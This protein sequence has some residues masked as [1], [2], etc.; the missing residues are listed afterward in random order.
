MAT[1]DDIITMVQIQL[2]SSS[3]LISD[4]GYL[5][6][7]T[8]AESELNWSTPVTDNTQIQWL[9]KRTLRHCIFIL[10]VAAAQKFKY[11]QVNLQQRFE[12]YE[13]LLA[14]LDKEYEKA[15]TEQIGTFANVET[16]KQFGT[17]IGAGFVYDSIGNDLTY[18]KV[19]K[20]LLSYMVSE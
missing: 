4:D 13:K 18:T 11:K 3:T 10:W 7:L 15:I 20:N 6:A 12:H 14:A 9:M 1:A 17:A 2:S 16:Y 5:S 19:E 8:T